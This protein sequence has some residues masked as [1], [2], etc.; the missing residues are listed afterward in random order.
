MAAGK[1]TGT[2]SVGGSVLEVAIFGL[3]LKV[4]MFS[5]DFKRISGP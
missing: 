2:T 4:T 5:R 1:S 3:R